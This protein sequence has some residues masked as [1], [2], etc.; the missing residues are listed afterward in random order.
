MSV[1]N[2]SVPYLTLAY[3]LRHHITRHLSTRRGMS[4]DEIRTLMAQLRDDGY[5]LHPILA[6]AID[7]LVA[8]L[9]E[10][11]RHSSARPDIAGFAMYAP[12]KPRR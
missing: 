4:A 12:V 5:V 8:E 6:E 10:Q 1:Q 2:I 11:L 7:E 9:E 3:L